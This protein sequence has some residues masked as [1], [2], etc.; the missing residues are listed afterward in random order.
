MVTAILVANNV[1]D[2]DTDAATGKR[3]LAVLL[4]RERSQRLF[5]ALVYGTFVA[6]GAFAA[7]DL[8]PRWCAIA[9]IAI[10]MARPLVRTINAAEDGPS[11]IGV[12]QG[13]ARLHLVVAIGLALGAALS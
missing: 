10:P 8:L 9:I 3:T 7:F 1:R 2:V 4:G 13:T 5:A 12:L 6:I 11:L